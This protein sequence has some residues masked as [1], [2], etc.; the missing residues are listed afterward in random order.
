GGDKHGLFICEVQPTSVA[1]KAGLL[2]ADKIF[3]V[4][5]IDFTTLTREEAVLCLMNM[6]TS[7]V[8]MIVANLRHEYEQLLADVGGDSFYIRAHF[9]YNTTNDEE[10]SI[11]V[12]DIFHVTDTLYNGQVGSWVA[13]KLNA[14]PTMTK[15]TGAIPNK[16]RAEQ[17]A[18]IAPSLEQLLKAKQPSFKRKL[19]SKFSDKRSRSVSS[20]NH[21]KEDSTFAKALCWKPLTSS[22][23]P[24]Y[25][26]VVLKAVTIIRPVVLF[27]PLA[28]IARDRLIKDYPERF[29]LPRIEMHSPTKARANVIK[30]QSIKNVIQRNRHCLLDVTPTAVEQLNYAQCYPIVIYFKALDRRQ[31]KQIRQEYGKLYQ[32]SSRRLFESSERLEFLYS[33]LFTSTIKLDSTTNW[34]KI[35]KSQIEIQQEQSIWMSDDRPADKDLPNSDEYFISTRQSYSDDNTTRD[36]SSPDS[37][38]NNAHRR[39]GNNYLQRVASDPVVFPRDKIQ[40]YSTDSHPDFDEEEDE[41]DEEDDNSAY[42]Q[43]S[44]MSLPNRSHSVTEIPTLNGEKHRR[45][46]EIVHSNSTAENSNYYKKSSS[47]IKP[48]NENSNNHFQSIVNNNEELFRTDKYNNNENPSRIHSST[49]NG[50][51]VYRTESVS[52]V[53]HDD[54]YRLQRLYRVDDQDKYKTHYDNEHFLNTQST[55]KLLQAPLM[56]SQTHELNGSATNTLNGKPNRIPSRRP[57]IAP[58]LR[59]ANPNERLSSSDSGGSLQHNINKN[60][61]HKSTI[62]PM[63]GYATWNRPLSSSSSR[64]TILPSPS[65]GHHSHMN[66]LDPS[67]RITRCT[68]MDT[69]RRNEQIQSIN[70]HEKLRAELSLKQKM[71]TNKKPNQTSLGNSIPRENSRSEL[72]P[73]II[74]NVYYESSN[75]RHHYQTGDFSLQKPRV[76]THD[77]PTLL[78]QQQLN[79]HSSSSTSSSLSVKDKSIKEINEARSY[80]S[81]D[82]CDVIGGARGVLGY[83][84]GKLVCPLT[85]VSISVPIG[86]IPEGVQQEIYF[87]VCQDGTNIPTFNAKQGE[88]L[89]S[90]IVMCGPHGVQFLKPVELILPH[91]AGTDA[92]QLALMLHGAN[93]N[94]SP[95]HQPDKSA[96]LNGINHVTSSNVSILVD[97][98]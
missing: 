3:S 4:N 72:Y 15:V 55:V 12:N 59:T 49:S 83:Y 63:N 22:K 66:S 96:I 93:Q 82:P 39:K 44:S 6:K 47:Y 42:M 81:Q 53:E 56:K 2:V 86:A 45:R 34:Y 36:E 8:N 17:L 84:G 52:H 97:H 46:S 91:C 21:L 64:P 58:K 30:L 67:N 87:Q 41:D 65:N 24:A 33:Y 70:P 25:E 89:L 16:T 51:L 50:H 61:T 1:H 90:P 85:G 26:R 54:I 92:Q 18:S 10:L 62:T 74:P 43:N 13:T 94:G 37:E 19:R 32:K 78:M 35:L 88:R 95:N 57:L 38:M 69:V 48:I 23:F 40:S 98:F 77:D 68:S 73:Q 14:P 80:S 7:Q 27:G 29:E 60:P 9:T 28:D 71:S 11:R 75:D 76:Y 20:I 5:N 31:I 79:A